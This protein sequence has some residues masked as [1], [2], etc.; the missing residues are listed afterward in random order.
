MATVMRCIVL[1]FIAKCVLEEDASVAVV[2]SA[3]LVCVCRV[4][5]SVKSLVMGSNTV[6]I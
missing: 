3:S 4:A 5:Y 2:R 1:P 6:L